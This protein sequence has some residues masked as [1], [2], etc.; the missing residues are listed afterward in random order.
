MKIDISNKSGLHLTQEK[1]YRCFWL[2]LFL[3]SLVILSLY[4]LYQKQIWG[5][6]NDFYDSLAV[7]DKAL[8]TLQKDLAHLK[9]QLLGLEHE[10]TIQLASNKSLS[11]QLLVSEEKLAKVQKK[12]SLYDD[13]LSVDGFKKG[14]VIQYFGV[15]KD[16]RDETGRRYT[17]TL[18]LSHST[19]RGTVVNGHYQLLI[20]GQLKGNKKSFRHTEI[21]ADT[22]VSHDRFSLKYYQSLEGGIVLPEGFIPK[23]IKL[24]LLP[25]TKEYA[26]KTKSYQWLPLLNSI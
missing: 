17:Y 16:K 10:R 23:K 21:A 15:N 3:A 8:T 18:V 6:T 5:F 2:I 26:K 24:S 22:T 19:R 7:Q 4:L 20:V 1:S 11:R 13:I 9:Q 14:L 12:Q 25:L